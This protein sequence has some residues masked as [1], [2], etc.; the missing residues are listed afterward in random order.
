MCKVEKSICNI[1]NTPL[2][3]PPATTPAPCPL[4]RA[5]Q[6][7]AVCC[8]SRNADVALSSSDPLVPSRHNRDESTGDVVQSFHLPALRT[9]AVPQ[10][11]PAIQFDSLLGKGK[12]KGRGGCPIIPHSITSPPP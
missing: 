8:Q 11:R 5:G 1:V 6:C 4:L 12:G 7:D 9:R 2:H 3:I 10:W